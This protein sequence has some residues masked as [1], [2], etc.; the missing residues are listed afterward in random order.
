[1]TS[2]QFIMIEVFIGILFLV[3]DVLSERRCWWSISHV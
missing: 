1:V 3:K 2:E